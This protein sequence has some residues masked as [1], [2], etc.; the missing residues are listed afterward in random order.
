MSI[1]IVKNKCRTKF[2]AKIV[3]KYLLIIKKARDEAFL[4]ELQHFFVNIFCF[5]RRI[6]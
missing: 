5:K 2:G 1:H 3:K 4:N 6:L